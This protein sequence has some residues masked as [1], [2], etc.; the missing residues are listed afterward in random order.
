MVVTRNTYQGEGSSVPGYSLEVVVTRNTYQGE[1]CS[2]PG[3]NLS[4]EG[5]GDT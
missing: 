2:V 3:Y 1:G 4:P 5:G